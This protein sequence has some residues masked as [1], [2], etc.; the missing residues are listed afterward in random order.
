MWT[1]KG[2]LTLQGRAKDTI[3]LSG[4]ENLEPVPIEAMIE[5]SE[6]IDNVVVVG[7]DKRFIAAL[8][9]INRQNVISYLK[10]KD[11]PFAE[12][13]LTTMKEVNALINNWIESVVNLAHGFKAYER[14]SRF[15]LIDNPFSL[16]KELSAKQELKRFAIN[17]LYK[18]EID[19]LF[20]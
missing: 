4:G 10:E 19:K 15:T 8:I 6:F 14:I 1:G 18:E 13:K 3:V 12:N 16:G 9:V 20:A 17:E 7:Q 5:Q 2:N 11:I